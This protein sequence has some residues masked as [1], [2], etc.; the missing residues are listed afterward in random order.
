VS[1]A[2]LA[3]AALA[4]AGPAGAPPAPLPAAPAPAAAPA[5]PPAAAPSSPPPAAAPAAAPDLPPALAPVP[6]AVLSV[7]LAPAEAVT[8]EQAVERAIRFA[9]T[10]VVAAQEIARAEGLM[11]QARAAALPYVAAGGT[12]T[13]LDAPRGVVAGRVAQAQSTLYGYATVGVPLLAPQRWVAWAHGAQGVDVA[14]ASE[15]DVRR[16]VALTAARG[17][18]TVVAARRAVEVSE[19][20]VAVARAH[21]D[22][23]AARRRGGVGNELDLRRAEQELAAA[24]VQLAAARSAVSRSQEALGVACGAGG[25]LDAA[26]IAAVPPYPDLA[27]A[28]QGVDARADVKAARERLR[29]ADAVWRDSWVDWLPVL[30]GTLTGF[31]QDPATTAT[32]GS[33]W[34]AQLVLAVPLFE[35]GLRPAQSRERGAVAREAEAGVEGAL[36]QARSEVRLSFETLR[37][38]LDAYAASRRGAGSAA[39]ALSLA[40]E[41]YRAG[42]TSNLDLIDA[43]R[44]ARDAALTAVIAE[45]AVRQA[46]LDLLAAAGRFP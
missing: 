13:Y 12:W 16:A 3:L 8:F 26:G 10:S 41:A 32:P 23:S 17:F 9:T 46:K 27:Q 38:A 28:E 11:G 31:L 24:E 14:I 15:A 19:S 18:L 36:R 2:A 40:N 25:P 44:R 7:R 21:F 39:A 1:L 6:E 5:S 34:A 4:A 35:G 20:A 37:N 43:E 33:G 22:F 42:A 30:T 29:A 45:D